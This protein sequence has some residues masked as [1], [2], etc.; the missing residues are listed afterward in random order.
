[1]HA[2]PPQRPLFVVGCPRSGTTLVQCI[3]SASSQAYSLPETHFFSIVLPRLGV[4]FDAALSGSALEQAKALLRDEA[5]LDLPQEVWAS[6]PDVSS[7]TGCSPRAVFEAVLRWHRPQDRPQEDW[8][9]IEK[10]PLHVLALDVIQ[11]AYPDALF[12]NV[13]RDPIDVTSSWIGVPFATT[14]SMLS[15][16]RSWREAVAAA[17]SYARRQPD[18]SFTVVYESLVLNPDKALADL[19]AFTGLPHEPAM[20][21]AFGLQAERNVGR[22][23]T[24]KADVQRGQILNRSGV[25]QERLSRGQAWLVA[26]ATTSARER[27]GYRGIDGVGLPERAGAVIEEARVRYAEARRS[28][29]TFGAARHAAATL[30]AMGASAG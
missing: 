8:R 7:E 4:P 28:E 27:Y 21:E 20:L 14:R 3:L 6:L 19:C 13:V 2:I 17:E 29:G 10:T 23:E 18:H 16:A 26:R 11:S 24:W 12:V 30:R 9:V 15:Y 5:R 25:W 22:Q 1:M